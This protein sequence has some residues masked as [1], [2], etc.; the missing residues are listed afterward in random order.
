LIIDARYVAQTDD[1]EIIIVRN[2][3]GL[4]ALVPVFEAKADGP[5]AWINENN[6]LSSNPSVGLGS[7]SLTIYA[8]R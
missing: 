2:C 5:Y 4:G 1:N 7:V 3:G 8:K 6:W